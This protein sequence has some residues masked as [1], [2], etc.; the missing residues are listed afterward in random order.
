MLPKLKIHSN[1]KD[2][3]LLKPQTFM[4]RSGQAVG[5]VARYYKLQAE[6]ILVAHDELDLEVGDNRLKIQR[7]PR[8]A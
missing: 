5:A 4:N 3:I 2:I 8:W 6:Q 7:W 1:S